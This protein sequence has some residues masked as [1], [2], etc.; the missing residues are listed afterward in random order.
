VQQTDLVKKHKDFINKL[1]WV[2]EDCTQPEFVHAFPCKINRGVLDLIGNLLPI[3]ANIYVDDIVGAAAF[4]FNMLKLLA[5]FIEAIFLVC[6]TPNV[7]V[8]Q[9][10][11]SLEKWYK[12]IVGP[13]QIILGLVVDTNKMT[14]GMTDEY[15]QQCHDLLNLWD[16]NQRFFKV[17]DMQKLV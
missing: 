13:R 10:P 14:V 17:G 8:R 15:I 9:C 6:G 12:L 5:A 16:Q 11:L 1:H 3:T 7:S 2:E 4:R